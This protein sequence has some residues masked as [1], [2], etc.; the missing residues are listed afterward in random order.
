MEVV[1]S[2]E[3]LESLCT[4]WVLA[5]T[6]EECLGMDAL[7]LTMVEDECSITKQMKNRKNRARDQLGGGLCYVEQPKKEEEEFEEENLDF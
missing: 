4:G 3:E 7:M 6:K 2:R 5:S 1:Q